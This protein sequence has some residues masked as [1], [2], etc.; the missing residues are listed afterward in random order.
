[1][2]TIIEFYVPKKFHRNVVRRPMERGRLIQFGSH[3]QSRLGLTVYGHE[4]A[5]EEIVREVGFELASIARKYLRL[6]WQLQSFGRHNA[7]ET[8]PRNKSLAV[9]VQEE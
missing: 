3:A 4:S 1:M 7:D 9:E 6:S 5:S 8:R 2:A